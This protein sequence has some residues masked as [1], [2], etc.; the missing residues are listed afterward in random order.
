MFLRCLP[1][2]KIIVLGLI[3]CS[4]SILARS[5]SEYMWINVTWVKKETRFF[6]LPKHFLPPLFF[7]FIPHITLPLHYHTLNFLR[8]QLLK[9][10][11]VHVLV[12]ITCT[13]DHQCAQRKSL[14]YSHTFF[15]YHSSHHL[16]LNFKGPPR[17]TYFHST[18]NFHVLQL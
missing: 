5:I 16:F 10:T 17:N 4:K 1:I 15:F 3:L 18:T 11:V 14:A 6:S 2:G 9:S 13:Q 8:E 12:R 7:S